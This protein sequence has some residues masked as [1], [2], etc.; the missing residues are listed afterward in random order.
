MITEWFPVKEIGSAN[1]ITSM[2]IPLGSVLGAAVTG[3]QFGEGGDIKSTLEGVIFK[4]NILVTAIWLLFMTTFADKPAS[5]PS[6]AAM[7]P[8]VKRDLAANFRELSSNRNFI[9]IAFYYCMMF[10]SYTTLGNL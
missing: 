10:G 6:A 1:A 9:L 3:S 2:A 8:P 7:E 4:M 5:P